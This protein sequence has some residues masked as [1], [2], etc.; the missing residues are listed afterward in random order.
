[1]KKK[2]QVLLNPA[3]YAMDKDQ[4]G[5]LLESANFEA[6]TTKAKEYH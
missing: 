5:Y 1:M 4:N 3:C 2:H 6:V